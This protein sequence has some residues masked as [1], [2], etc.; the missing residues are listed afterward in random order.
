MST[1]QLVEWKWAGETEVL[2]ENLAW[3]V[4]R[5]SLENTIITKLVRKFIDFFFLI[6]ETHYM[7]KTAYYY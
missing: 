4:L 6:P 3:H 1:N 7:F 5:A 2:G